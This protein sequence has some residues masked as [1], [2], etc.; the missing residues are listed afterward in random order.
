MND[1]RD[2]QFS[3]FLKELALITVE[4]YLVVVVLFLA[5]KFTVDLI[6]K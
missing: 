6:L 4:L 5:I 3:K 2:A 1:H